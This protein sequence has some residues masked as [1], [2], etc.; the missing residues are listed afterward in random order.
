VARPLRRLL[1]ATSLLTF[2][3]SLVACSGFAQPSRGAKQAESKP[4]A[5]KEG[6]AGILQDFR[7]DSRAAGQ[8]YKGRAVTLSGRFELAEWKDSKKGPHAFVK[9][10]EGKDLVTAFFAAKWKAPLDALKQG[11]EVKVRGTLLSGSKDRES[12]ALM[13][14]LDDC[15]LVK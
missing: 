4:L 6:A 12:G 3:S 8:L 5:P 2:L 9:A 10:G 13:I 1:L 14:V 15:E 11:D 7:D